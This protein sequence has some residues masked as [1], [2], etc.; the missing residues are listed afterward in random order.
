MLL[1]RVRCEAMEKIRV[2]F[3]RN[4]CRFL[5]PKESIFLICDT[6]LSFYNKNAATNS[7]IFNIIVAGD[8][9]QVIICAYGA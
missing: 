4:L 8:F 9:F 5:P 2:Y 1:N 6:L 7:R 3:D